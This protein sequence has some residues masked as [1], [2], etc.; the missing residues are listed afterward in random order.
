MTDYLRSV[1]A[2]VATQ[3]GHHNNGVHRD[4]H[5][6]QPAQTTVATPDTKADNPITDTDNEADRGWTR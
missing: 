5:P 1:A 2:Y 6:G 3:S 4:G